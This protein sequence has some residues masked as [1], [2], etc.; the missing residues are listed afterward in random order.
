MDKIWGHVIK[1]AS[2]IHIRCH[3]PPYRVLHHTFLE[4]RISL[5]NLP[6]LLEADSIMLSAHCVLI[7]LVLGLDSLGQRTPA[8]LRENSLFGHNIDSW[9]ICVLICSI[10]SNAHITS[11]D[12]CHSLTRLIE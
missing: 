6:N 10:L 4:V 8:S 2:S 9:L 1:E 7:E 5:L 11:P 3:W 12:A